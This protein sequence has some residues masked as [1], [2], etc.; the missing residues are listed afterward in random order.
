[1]LW[2]EVK[3]PVSEPVLDLATHCVF[4]FLGQGHECP[5]E[6]VAIDAEPNELLRVRTADE[7]C[8]CS[9]VAG[10]RGT[11]WVTELSVVPAQ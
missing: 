7:P 6:V 9:D 2:R 1:M 11:T 5:H 4:G 10:G 8:S 3:A